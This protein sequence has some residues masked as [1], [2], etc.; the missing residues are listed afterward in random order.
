MV[1]LV[2]AHIGKRY[3]VPVRGTK[4]GSIVY[5][6]IKLGCVTNRGT[7]FNGPGSRQSINRSRKVQDVFPD[8]GRCDVEVFK[9]CLFQEY[10]ILPHEFNTLHSPLGCAIPLQDVAEAIL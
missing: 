7:C 6:F 9:K 2:T 10:S 5:M 8:T 4:E 1:A 3:C